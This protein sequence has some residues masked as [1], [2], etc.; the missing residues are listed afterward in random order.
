MKR[1][2]AR[3]NYFFRDAYSEFW[4]TITNTFSQCGDRIGDAW[5]KLAD[6]FGALWENI[7][8]IISFQSIFVNFFKAIWHA[9]VLGFFVGK[10]V[11]SAVLIPAICIIFSAVQIVAV[12]TIM[13]FVYLGYIVFAFVDWIYCQL[14]KISTSCP[15]CQEK[16]SLPTYVCECGAKHTKLVPRRY[17]ILTRE[18]KCGRS[19]RTTFFNGRQKMSGKWVCPT[20]GYELGGPLQVDIPIPVVGGPSSGKT[21]YI[22]MAIS[23]IEK[24][25]GKDYNLFF[26]Y[27][28]NA[29]LGD[30]YKENQEQMSKGRLPFKTNDTRLRY[31]QFYLTPKGEKVRNLIS[32]CDVAG[33]A[34]EKKDEIDRQIG[35]KNANAF[36]MLV[37]PLSVAAYRE[38]VRNLI[39]LRKY[40]ASERPMD[41]ILDA[42]IHTL[43]SMKCID[44]KSIIKTDVALIFT[45]CDI[46][47]LNEKIGAEGVA[48]YKQKH[49]ITSTYEAQNKVCEQ[50][51]R[52]YEEENFLNSVKSKFKSVQFFTCSALGHIENGKSFNPKGVEDPVLWLIDK[53]S[54]SINLKKK[55]GKKI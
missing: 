34:Y 22:S 21:C 9:L 18:C 53:A 4:G 27:K 49:N 43:E 6:S 54:A 25:A 48:R 41:E 47:G 30:D 44:S 42:L 14:K 13:L 33:E 39:D 7:L 24:T 16:Y 20:C 19:L 2:P 40:G 32:I 38:E 45:K 36:L 35:F 15:N 3:I 31:Y 17:G 46:P 50:F 10:L 5:E 8:N 29:A 51:L 28:E 26:E 1:Q 55:W 52:E 23:Q 12:V 37:D 11:L